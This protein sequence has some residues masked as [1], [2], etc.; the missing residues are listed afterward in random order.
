MSNARLMLISDCE[1]WS[2]RHVVERVTTICAAAIPGSVVV[3]LRDR[4]LPARERLALGQ[5]LLGAAHDNGQQLIVNERLDLAV[6]LGADGVHLPEQAVPADEARHFLMQQRGAQ[7]WLSC[8]SHRATRVV[9]DALDAVVLSPILAQRK[10]RPA[11]GLAALNEA[12]AVLQAGR[13]LFALGGVDAARA[14]QCLAAGADGVAVIGAAF[15]QDPR[16]L[17]TALGISRD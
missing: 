6:L 7:P 16:L 13:R 2:Q 8:A 17:L 1:R 15:D 5:Q 14:A 10:G 9:S 12:R 11:L 3:Q 4:Q